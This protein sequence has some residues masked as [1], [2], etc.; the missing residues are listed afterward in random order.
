MNCFPF[1][2]NLK[3]LI[4]L[5]LGIF[6]IA[7]VISPTLLFGQAK[8]GSLPQKTNSKLASKPEQIQA[9]KILF[10]G[11]SFTFWRGGLD[12]HLQVL[13]KSMSPP[14]GYQ[15]K[16][17]T[18]GGASLKVMWKKTSAVEEIKNGKYDIVIL[19]DDIPETTIESF[20]IYSKK[21]VDLVRETG[22]RPILF[23]TW[24]YERLDWISME[25]IANAHLK[26]SQELKVEVAPVGIAWGLS[27][28]RLP[29]LNMYDADAEHPSVAGMYLSLLMIES[30]ISGKSPLTRSPKKL[31]IPKLKQLDA[32]RRKDLQSVAEDAL[33]IWKRK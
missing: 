21:F 14:L 10:I 30:T 20:R 17:V 2:Q 13:S 12:R 7:I 9:K 23:M 3:P 29:D 26:V 16:S 33:K 5:R 6:L 1:L 27:R 25:E 19:Q 32:D 24:D 31:P 11:N 18:R 8:T 22:A 28:K 4:W 15:A